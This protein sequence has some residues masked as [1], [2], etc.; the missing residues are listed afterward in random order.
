ML[1]KKIIILILIAVAVVLLVAGFLY[2]NKSAVNVQTDQNQSM[3]TDI[4]ELSPEDI[5]LELSASPD[6]NKVQF[7]I[8][9][10]SDIIEVAYEL[11]YEADSSE[12]DI[13]EGAEARIQRGVTGEA[14][15]NPGDS[16]YQS[17]WLDLGS[18]SKNV[19]RYDK[20]VNSV[21][22]I[23][24]ITKDNNKI[25]KTEKEFIL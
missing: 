11:N 12:K 8:S 24:K 19:C 14:K 15:L 7:K 4:Q 10:L 17:P 1:N 25:Y 9:N 22:I 23:L 6:R 21:N 13:S 3:D 5:G 20:G 16:E 2:F 18:C